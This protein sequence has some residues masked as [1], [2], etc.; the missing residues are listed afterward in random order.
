LDWSD[1][2]DADE[3]RLSGCSAFRGMWDRL[4][5]FGGELTAKQRAWVKGVA[6]RLFDTNLPKKPPARKT[7]A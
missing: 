4:N 7:T 5:D 2:H 6:E 3:H 1:E